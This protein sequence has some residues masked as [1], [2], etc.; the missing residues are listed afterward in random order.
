MKCVAGRTWLTT[1]IATGTFRRSKMNP[2]SIN[3]GMKLASSAIWLARNWLRV[4]PEMN[5]PSDSDTV[6]YS[7]ETS[8]DRQQRASNRHLEQEL[9]RQ[10]AH[11][12]VD[13]RR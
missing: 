4:T 3:A 6:R 1:W 10:Q 7:S 12:Q 9:R 5:R 13:R 8:D 11:E 2:E